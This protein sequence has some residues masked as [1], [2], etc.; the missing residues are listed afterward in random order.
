MLC[1]EIQ[2]KCALIKLLEP[3]WQKFT[4]TLSN[5]VGELDESFKGMYSRK[6]S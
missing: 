3:V 5:T 4:M 2:I 6:R 1:Q